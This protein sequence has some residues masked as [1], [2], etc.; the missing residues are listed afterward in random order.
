MPFSQCKCLYVMHNI[1][2]KIHN[3][4]IGKTLSDVTHCCLTHRK[5]SV[6]SQFTWMWYPRKPKWDN[7][8]GCNR[9]I[10]YLKREKIIWYCLQGIPH[11]PLPDLVHL[12]LRNFF[13]I[14]YRVFILYL[15]SSSWIIGTW[16]SSKEAIITKSCQTFKCLHES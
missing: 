4:P 15:K 2:K 7:K 3:D 1:K 16:S 6:V 5:S 13:T 9:K 12:L 8:A 11:L 10:N 14:P